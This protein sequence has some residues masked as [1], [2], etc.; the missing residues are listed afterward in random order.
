M[1]GVG[2]KFI[3]QRVIGLAKLAF[4]RNIL[5]ALWPVMQGVWSWPTAACGAVLHRQAMCADATAQARLLKSGRQLQ[6]E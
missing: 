5:R 1:L 4:S 3:R 6:T 2:K